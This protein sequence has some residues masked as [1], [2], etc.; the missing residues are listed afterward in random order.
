[1][2]YVL[3]SRIFKFSI[4]V[5]YNIYIF[6]GISAFI[7]PRDAPG[8]S[9]GKKEDKL[10]I[11]ASST[12]NVIMEDCVIPKENLLGKPG[13]G[14]KIAMETLDGGRIGIAGQALGN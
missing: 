3:K 4:L 14:F 12:S 8:L 11:R 5:I 7:V 1:M 9:L 2:K 13:M 10:G 6:L